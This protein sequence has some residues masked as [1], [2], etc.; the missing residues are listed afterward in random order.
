MQAIARA[1]ARMAPGLSDRDVDRLVEGARRRRR[2]RTIR[3][4]ALLTTTAACALLLVAVVARRSPIPAEPPIAHGGPAPTPPASVE[5]TLRLHDGSKATP[6]D[7]ASEIA[8]VAETAAHVGL[9]LARGAGRFEVAPRPERTFTVDAGEV[10]ITVVG[11]VFSVERI[12]DRVGV[13]VERGTVRVE[14]AGGLRVLNRGEG[15]WF[16]PLAA[17]APPEPKEPRRAVAKPDKARHEAT[18]ESPTA[19]KVETAGELLLAADSL[20][21]AGHADQAVLL[22]RRI[23][24]EHPGD[25]RAPLAAFT[26]GRVLLMELGRPREAATAFAEVRRMSPDGAFAEDALAREVEAWSEAGQA[27]QAKARAREYLRL[28]PSGRRTATVRTLG[29]LP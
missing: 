8:V 14:W 3:R 19:E 25:P 27:E 11:T 20:R 5:R 4:A 23:L 22:L 7:R 15:G 2:G 13:S 26:L 18:P 21:V 9:A 17:V 16:P 1:G 6:L 10:T 12:A 28:F 24:S 29:G